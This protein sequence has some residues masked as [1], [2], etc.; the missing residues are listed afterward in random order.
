MFILA[1]TFVQVLDATMATVQ[2]HI[3]KL[4]TLIDSI[5]VLDMLAAFAQVAAIN[6]GYVRPQCTETGA[7]DSELNM[8]RGSVR[9]SCWV[10][11]GARGCCVSPPHRCIAGNGR[12]HLTT[13][14]RLQHA[15]TL[16]NNH[17]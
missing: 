8:Q 11:H 9:G 14:R 15:L 7:H 16:I 17:L 13:H 10:Q 12:Y 1:L 5:A 3:D 2:Q 4:H 6:T